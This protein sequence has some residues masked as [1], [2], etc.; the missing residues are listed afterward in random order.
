MPK[1]EIHGM[2]ERGS[3]KS[4]S[5]AEAAAGY[6]CERSRKTRMPVKII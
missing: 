3:Q 4:R 5:S 6:V 1:K 2:K